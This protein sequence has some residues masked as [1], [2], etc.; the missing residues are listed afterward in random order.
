MEMMALRVIENGGFISYRTEG[1]GSQS[2]YELNITWYSAINSY[3]KKETD[4]LQVK[5]YLASRAIALI[6]QGVPGIYLHGLLGSKNDAEAVIEDEQTRSINRKSLNK[7]ELIRALL[8]PATTTYKVSYKLAGLIMSR[9]HRKAFHP[10]AKQ[11]IIEAEE[12]FFTVLRTSNDSMEHILAIINVTNKN[13]RF[14]FEQ[15]NLPV[16][17]DKWK[18]IISKKE[19][20]TANDIISLELEPYDIFWLKPVSERK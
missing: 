8:D 20:N 3:N 2:P 6:L 5:R 12:C 7:T 9:S 17:S 19:F 1:D 11:R 10:N 14:N 4:E 13:Q 18:D 15:I 16:S